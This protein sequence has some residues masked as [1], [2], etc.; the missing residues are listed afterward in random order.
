[1]KTL[2]AKGPYC[3]LVDGC[4]YAFTLDGQKSWWGATEWK[5]ANCAAKEDL[6]NVFLWQLLEQ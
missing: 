4:G 3:V 1:M 2:G 6:S 5:A